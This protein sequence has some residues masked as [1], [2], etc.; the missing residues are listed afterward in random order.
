LKED[1]IP[2]T[3][4]AVAPDNAA[5]PGLQFRMGGIKSIQAAANHFRQSMLS[6]Q[7]D[8]DPIPA[9]S[10]VPDD[11]PDGEDLIEIFLIEEG[12]I[13]I[14]EPDQFGGADGNGCCSDPERSLICNII[15]ISV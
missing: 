14:G 11:A 3:P 5:V 13:F 10:H 2:Q 8:G 12:F 15:E 7:Q 9:L 1:N 6:F 4:G